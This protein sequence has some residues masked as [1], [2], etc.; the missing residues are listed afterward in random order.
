MFWAPL[1]RAHSRSLRGARAAAGVA[2]AGMSFSFGRNKTLN[3]QPWLKQALSVYLLDP[4]PF[5]ITPN[6]GDKHLL[7]KMIMAWVRYVDIRQEEKEEAAKIN[8][9]V[10]EK[11]ET[12]SPSPSG[13]E[14]FKSKFEHKTRGNA[15]RC[16][17][18]CQTCLP[19]LPSSH[20]PTLPLTS[21]PTCA[22]TVLEWTCAQ[23]RD[24]G[25]EKGKGGGG[26]KGDQ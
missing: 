16:F 20:M 19:L 15:V 10:K 3:L 8:G 18:R 1:P 17:F 6:G 12:M 22:P 26:G 23:G 5:S 14:A 9:V 13:K 4:S 11:A 2:R 24:R 21:L 25:G 7:A